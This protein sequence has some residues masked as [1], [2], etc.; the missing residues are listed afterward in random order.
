MHDV[1]KHLLLYKHIHLLSFWMIDITEI[2]RMFLCVN[3]PKAHLRIPYIWIHT[4][5][6][7]MNS[8]SVYLY[9]KEKYSTY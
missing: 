2:H 3:V 9:L 4:T 6:T 1:K 8:E 5:H 7:Y